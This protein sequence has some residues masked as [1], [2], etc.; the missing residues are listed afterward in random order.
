[1]SRDSTLAFLTYIYTGELQCTASIQHELKEIAKRLELSGLNDICNTLTSNESSNEKVADEPKSELEIIKLGPVVDIKDIWGESDSDVDDDDGLCDRKKGGTDT[2]FDTD[3]QEAICDEDYHDI[4]CTQKTHNSQELRLDPVGFKDD[5]SFPLTMSKG[6]ASTQEELSNTISD[7]T[8]HNEHL[9]LS[10][11]HPGIER[12]VHEENKSAT[13]Q[14][15]NY[16]D[17]HTSGLDES[18][19]SF[20]SAHHSVLGNNSSFNAK[21][22]HVIEDELNHKITSCDKRIKESEIDIGTEGENDGTEEMISSS[23]VFD[24][25]GG[26][27]MDTSN[28]DLFQSPSSPDLALQSGSVNNSPSSPLF[29]KKRKRLFDN[30]VIEL[31]L[32]SEDEGQKGD[33]DIKTESQVSC[34]DWTEKMS[35]EN[36]NSFSQQSGL[37]RDENSVDKFNDKNENKTNVSL[38]ISP[39]KCIDGLPQPFTVIPHN[40]NNDIEITGDNLIEVKSKKEKK[41]EATFLGPQIN[42]RLSQ[43][44][45]HPVKKETE[46]SSYDLDDTSS[47]INACD[48]VVKCPELLDDSY[49]YKDSYVKLL[50]DSEGHRKTES[51]DD[52]ELMSVDSES[53]NSLHEEREDIDK[54]G[55]D[56]KSDTEQTVNSIVEDIAGMCVCVFFNCYHL[57]K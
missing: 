43:P 42:F 38:H 51:D 4:M 55:E 9:T 12:K 25:S 27:R 37:K 6:R 18:S 57:T 22:R 44:S 20:D 15:E 48:N 46:I 1:M 40:D 24:R 26:P 3:I 36:T 13:D 32:E 50:K 35:V 2:E 34:D 8:D 33:K 52:I 39:S 21:Q 47:K 16:E 56:V 28:I 31:D 14:P 10:Y 11:L 7:Q 54:N 23:Q 41:K 19:K 29:N 30:H 45:P 5:R 49:T 53:N 17:S